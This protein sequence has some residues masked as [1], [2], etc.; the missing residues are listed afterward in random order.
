MGVIRVAVMLAAKVA[1]GTSKTRSTDR[2]GIRLVYLLQRQSQCDNLSNFKPHTIRQLC[3]LYHRGLPSTCMHC[4]AGCVS[5]ESAPSTSV[6][7]TG[8][9]RKSALGRPP[10]ELGLL[11]SNYIQRYSIQPRAVNP[12][13]I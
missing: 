9:S 10:S 4:P 8:V 1:F 2:I 12:S 13:F 7:S 5:V 11:K 6:L 3:M